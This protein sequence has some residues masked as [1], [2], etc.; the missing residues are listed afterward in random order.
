LRANLLLKAVG[1]GGFRARVYILAESPP[2]GGG[3]GINKVLLKNGAEIRPR[4]A[5]L[6]ARS[7]HFFKLYMY[8]YLKNHPFL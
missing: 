3:G 8:E 2:P 5:A 1:V 7:A 6:C 4:P